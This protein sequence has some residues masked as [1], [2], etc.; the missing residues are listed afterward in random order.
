[1]KRTIFF[2]SVI[3]MLLAACAS[4]TPEMK[5]EMPTA[6]AMMKGTPTPDAMMQKEMPTVDAM[7]QT[8]P[9]PD[10]MMKKMPEQMFAAH[11]VDSMP[12]HGDVV[13]KTPEKL[14]L[15]FNFTLADNST[16][17]VTKDGAPVS[18]GTVMLGDKM[19]SMSTTLPMNAGD[20]LYLVKYK[21][22]WLDKSCHD[23]QFAFQVGAMMK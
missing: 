5:K 6:D 17:T 18:T 2:V 22:C 23:G 9:T 11:F 21:A 20:G 3:A 15:N 19:L 10:A 1:M 12:K 4:P 16:I 14:L 8:T 7:M 13:A